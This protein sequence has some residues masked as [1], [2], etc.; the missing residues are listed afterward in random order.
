M[1]P[2]GRVEFSSQN[3]CDR[4]AVFCSA[5]LQAVSVFGLDDLPPGRRVRLICRAEASFARLCRVGNN[6]TLKYLGLSFLA[7]TTT[8]SEGS[9]GRLVDV[10]NRVRSPPSSGTPAAG[11]DR[12]KNQAWRMRIL[13]FPSRRSSELCATISTSP[14]RANLFSNAAISY[15]RKWRN[16]SS[17]KLVSPP[18]SSCRFRDRAGSYCCL[19]GG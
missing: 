11:G 3:A 14:S 16:S 12:Q 15:Q 1:A 19:S 7:L 6:L 5:T 17:V 8:I 9:K 10:S 13:H 18:R 4:V 2:A